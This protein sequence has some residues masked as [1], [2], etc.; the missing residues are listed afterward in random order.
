MR[1]LLRCGA[2]IL[3]V[4]LQRLH[5][6][7][8]LGDLRIEVRHVRP[9]RLRGLAAGLHSLLPQCLDGFGYLVEEVVNFVDIV[10]FLESDCL[11]GMLPYVLGRQQSHKSYTS[12]WA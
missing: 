6:C 7:S 11:E 2:K 3:I 10:A 1:P 5:L 4:T 8:Q 9:Q 12:L